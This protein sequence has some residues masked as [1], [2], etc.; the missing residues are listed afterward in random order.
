MTDM[1]AN[2]TLSRGEG[3][4]GVHTTAQADARLRK[5]Y[6]A[7]LRFKLYGLAAVSVA[8]LALVVLLASILH[9]GL[10]AF[11]STQIRLDVEFDPKV[12]DARGGREALL[13]ADWA[14]IVDAALEAKF[15]DATSRPARRALSGLVSPGAQQELRNMVIADPSLIGQKRTVWLTASSDVDMFMKGY[16]ERPKPGAPEGGR[17]NERSIGWI[18]RLVAEGAI[19]KRFNTRFFTAADSREP[20][21]VGVWGGIVGSF[22]TLLITLALAFPIGVAGAIYLEEFAPKNRFTD[23]IEVNINNL[24]AVP[25]IV[26]G[27][28][29][30]AVFINAFG[31]PRSA[32][33]VGGCVL[34]LMSLPIIIIAGRAA[35]KAVPPSIR[36]AALGVGASKMQMVLHHVLPL[37]MPG[38]LTGTILAM[39]HALGETAPLLMIG[40]VAF[41]VDIPTSPLQA[42]TVLPVQIF[43][44]AD[45]PERGFVEKTSA[46]II[47]LLVFLLAMNA[48][49]IYLRKK[50]ERKW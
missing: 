6:A 44:W 13:Q 18:D 38:M 50:F 41:V 29:G 36:E 1:V 5:R 9:G 32:P 23:L 47:V 3:R 2:G 33:L 7:E 20:E 39:A 42:A 40:M 27:L 8:I 24:A 10:T 46:A 28:L 37:A 21:L 35:L 22:Y 19:E 49:A 30:L 11:V 31:M 12:I 34:A 15:P 17:I 26:Y 14:K 25:S 4:R 16:Y 45:H 43:M 48:V